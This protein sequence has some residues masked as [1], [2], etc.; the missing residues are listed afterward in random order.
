MYFVT[1][2]VDGAERTGRTEVFAGSTT[3]TTFSV[4]NR[5]L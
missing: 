5:D 1:F 4:D 2:N 3:D